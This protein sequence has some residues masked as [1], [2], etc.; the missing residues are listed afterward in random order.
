MLKLLPLWRTVSK[1]T[2]TKITCCRSSVKVFMVPRTWPTQDNR[3]H[4][5]HP[6][7][8]R[9]ET[10]T[11]QQVTKVLRESES[12]STLRYAGDIDIDRAIHCLT[13]RNQTAST[14][15]AW[16]YVKFPTAV[17]RLRSSVMRHRRVWQL[18]N[19]IFEKPFASNFK[20]WRAK[21]QV[22]LE[23]CACPS[24]TASHYRGSQNW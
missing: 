22:P 5:H 9:N 23:S 1:A 4:I 3:R 10:R 8:T 12:N 7:T 13:T 20:P 6:Q 19:D 11:S 17:S 21:S 2:S 15:F 14:C 18:G 24:N 16:R